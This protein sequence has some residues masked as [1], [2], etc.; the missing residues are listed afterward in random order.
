MSE[1][2]DCCGAEPLG[3]IHDGFGMCAECHDHA[4]FKDQWFEE[5]TVKTAYDLKPI[6]DRRFDWQAWV[7]GEE[8]MAT[9]HGATEQ[10]A[11]DDLKEWLEM[12][13]DK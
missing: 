8:E 5:L 9:G 10:A 3:E 13:N 7:D 12:L 2:S 6:P 4:E 11:K 1:T